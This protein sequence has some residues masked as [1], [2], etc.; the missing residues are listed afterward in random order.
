MEIEKVI[1]IF[2]KCIPHYQMAIDEKWSYHILERNNMA[3]GICI[4]AV[5]RFEAPMSICDVFKKHY[6]SYINKCGYL[7]MTSW[8]G[9][10]NYL[11]K[12]ILPRLNFL[13]TEVKRLKKLQ[14]Q[15]Y[16]HI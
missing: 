10:S 11:N 7:F 2:E 4:L 16:T 13:K 3:Y 12:S 14:K 5:L 8:D 15:G 9:G 6:K 1:E